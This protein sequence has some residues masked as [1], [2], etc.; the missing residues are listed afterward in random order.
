MFLCF[1]QMFC[2]GSSHNIQTHRS[3]EPC[4]RTHPPPP[5]GLW[6]RFAI[7]TDAI[8]IT[9]TRKH[10]PFVRAP[11]HSLLLV[12]V[13]SPPQTHITGTYEYA[14]NHVH[15]IHVSSQI[16]RQ[17]CHQTSMLDLVAL[18]QCRLSINSV[19]RCPTDLPI[20]EGQG[21]PVARS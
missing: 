3:N 18:R 6:C 4:R 15:A 20:G 1:G 8:L 11:L 16:M 10:T 2:H 19:N 13:R 7:P 21:T 5:P 12:V 9:R 14:T 17:Q